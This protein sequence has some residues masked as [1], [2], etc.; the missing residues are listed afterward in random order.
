MTLMIEILEL[1][2][3]MMNQALE[4]N[5]LFD[6][7]KVSID[8]T[9]SNCYKVNFNN[10]NSSDIK[11]SYVYFHSNSYDRINIKFDDDL[12]PVMN[13]NYSLNTKLLSKLEYDICIRKQT[14]NYVFFYVIIF[15]T[16]DRYETQ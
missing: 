7:N 9:S 12:I 5:D 6:I 2:I 16:G 8:K 15:L 4:V 11:S 3:N 13:G 14:Y 1:M 10:C